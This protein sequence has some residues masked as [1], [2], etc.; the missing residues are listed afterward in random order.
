MR[1][2]V[3]TARSARLA[4]VRPDGRP[5]LV[6]IAFA[7]DG[8]RLVTA[9]DAKP[10]RTTDLQR[11][12]NVAAEPR[13]SVLVDHYDD[14]WTTLWWVRIDGYARV[15]EDGRERDAAVDLL[16]TR[17]EQYRVDRPRGP[18]IVVEATSWSGWSA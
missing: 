13:V 2:R 11:L 9:V 7:V 6:P 12:R 14:D 15:L 17:Y 5:H 1:R 8:D 16:A 10:K 3:G 18:A 4:T